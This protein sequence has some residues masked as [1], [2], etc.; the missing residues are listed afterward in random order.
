MISVSLQQWWNS[1]IAVGGNY[2]EVDYCSSE[3]NLTLQPV[4]T[5][6]LFNCHT[7]H[8]STHR[9]IHVRI[10]TLTYSHTHTGGK[11][12]HTLSISSRYLILKQNNI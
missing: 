2:F 12:S 10:R 9:H 8:I 1:C 4:S 5:V 7:M 6:S 11:K 3:K